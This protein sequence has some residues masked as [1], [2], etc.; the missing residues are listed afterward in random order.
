M[1]NIDPIWSADIQQQHFRLLLDAM[2][3]PGQIRQLASPPRTG[4][5]ALA[6]LAT[7]V[8]NEVTLADPYRLLSDLELSMLQVQLESVEQADFIL[9]DGHKAP[10][11]DPKLGSLP[12]PDQSA[13]LLL[14]LDQIGS[15]DKTLTLSGPGIADTQQLALEGL[16]AHW[17]AAREEWVASF[18]LG[19]DLIL[20]DAERFVA[21]PRTTTIRVM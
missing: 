5:S 12:D 3:R 11:F 15:G 9:C 7:L 10:S 16:H 21:I 14:T 20:I 6:L 8:D 1:L 17:I 18:P 19:V 4:T 13:T 2:S